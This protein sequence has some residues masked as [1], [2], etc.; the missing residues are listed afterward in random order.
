MCRYDTYDVRVCFPARHPLSS[1][2]APV[3]RIREYYIHEYIV[4]S[5]WV[6]ARNVEA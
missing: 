4:V 5:S 6:K 2:K 3:I 1:L